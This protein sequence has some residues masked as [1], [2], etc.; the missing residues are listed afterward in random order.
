[1]D[2]EMPIMNGLQALEQIMKTHPLPVVM[3][4]TL[5]EKGA[6]ETLRALELGAVDFLP[7]ELDGSILNISPHRRATS[8]QGKSCC[9]SCW[10]DSNSFGSK[11]V[12]WVSSNS[13]FSYIFKGF[14]TVFEQ[15]GSH[16]SS[17]WGSEE[18]DIGTPD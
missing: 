10:K 8:P 17:Q 11:N 3:I 18:T 1:M 4:S 5:T 6:T 12:K 13:F 14:D 9:Q 16:E 7:K 15:R 2:I